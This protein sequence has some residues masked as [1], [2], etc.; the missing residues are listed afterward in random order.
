MYFKHGAALCR[1]A[2][3]IRGGNSRGVRG[4]ARAAAAQERDSSNV[5][6]YGFAGMSDAT[7]APDGKWSLSLFT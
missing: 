5:S 7:K 6:V 1:D 3:A 2:D 4:M